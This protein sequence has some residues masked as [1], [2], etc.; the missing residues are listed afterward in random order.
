MS[1]FDL[2]IRGGTVIDGTG[3]DARQCDIGIKDGVITAIEP[4]IN[5]SATRD[6][7]ASGQIVTPGFIDVHTHYDGQATWDDHL[8]P[9]SNLG[10]TTVV[11]GNCGVGFAP[12]RA[13]DHEVLIELMEGVEEIPGTAM[14]EGLPWNWETFA[15]YLD[16]IEA[17]ARDIDVAAL[18]P[19]GPLRVYVMGERGVNREPATPDDIEKMKQLVREGMEAGAVGF[20]TSRTLVH[21]TSRGVPVPTYQAATDELKALGE[22]LSGEDGNV[23]QLISD[24][25][26]A[27]EEFSVLRHTAEKTGAKGTFTLLQLDNRPTEWQEQL[28]RIEQAQKD[29]LD[30][31]GQVLS[32]PVGM[33][34]GHPASMSIFSARPTFRKLR[35]T[36]DEDA[37][38]AELGKP[39]V[40]AQILSEDM[41]DPHIFAKIFANRL[42][43]MYPLAE[44]IEYM[45]SP[46]TSVAA[47]AEQA[48]EDQQSWL[49]DYF[50]GNGGKNLVFIPAANFNECIPELL[51]HPYTVAALGDGGAH[52]GT[53]CDASANVYVLTKWVKERRAF[54]LPQAIHM[55]TK[56]PAELYSMHDRGT[57]EVG[58]KADVNIINWDQLALKTPH[59]VHDLPAG[60]KRLLQT[61]D[62]ITATIV[63][64]EVIYEHGEPTGALPGKLIRGKPGRPAIA[65]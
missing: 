23:F 27:D 59:I 20:S 60:G 29:N 8:N 34:M 2:I 57:L 52:V 22:A 12:C 19:H 33:L 55:L 37:F 63:S 21:R 16:A 18:L 51:A 53:I 15:E 31:R 41:E 43:K 13:E 45:P 65:A 1:D 28:A 64:G 56:Q 11:M 17:R 26:D 36:L 3:A 40:K 47:L 49:Y 30:I 61:A 62:G 24:W 44:P 58:M 5:G 4:A 7:D 6:I 48:G 46:D 39:E 50:L 35:E 32:R 10:T 9:S 42:D 38:I 14:D 54:E 25:D